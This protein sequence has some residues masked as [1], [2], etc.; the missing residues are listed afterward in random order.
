MSY[1]KLYILDYHISTPS[2]SLHVAPWSPQE[3]LRESNNLRF[4]ELRETNAELSSLQATAT[5]AVSDGASGPVGNRRTVETQ[6]G[7][8]GK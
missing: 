5:T 7:D 2:M 8:L 3:G 6:L 1:F 4:E